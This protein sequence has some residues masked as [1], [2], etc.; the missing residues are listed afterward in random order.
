MDPAFTRRMWN[1][2][3]AC[4]Y[5]ERALL[6]PVDAIHQHMVGCKQAY[7]RYREKRSGC[8]TMVKDGK[9][10]PV[11][12][13]SSG[14]NRKK[15]KGAA[16]RR[17]HERLRCTVGTLRWRGHPLMASRLGEASERCALSD[18]LFTEEG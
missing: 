1:P 6:R 2:D 9:G 3:Q 11:G 16:L 13:P 17:A 15:L 4:K 5:E 8:V 18:R 12:D 7:V 10:R 14:S